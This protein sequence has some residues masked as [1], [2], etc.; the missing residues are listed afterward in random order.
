MKPCNK[1]SFV[2]LFLFI[3][4]RIL[5]AIY[6]YSFMRL[7]LFGGFHSDYASGDLTFSYSISEIN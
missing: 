2:Q 3:R 7:E 6:E 1:N 4:E 5:S